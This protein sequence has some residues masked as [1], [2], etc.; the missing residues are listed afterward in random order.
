MKNAILFY[1]AHAKY[2]LR[3]GNYKR[4]S[5][6]PSVILCKFSCQTLHDKHML[7]TCVP[8]SFTLP[9]SDLQYYPLAHHSNFNWCRTCDNNGQQTLDEEFSHMPPK[10]PHSPCRFDN[11]YVLRRS[12]S[13]I[14]E[15]V[16]QLTCIKWL[17]IYW[18][19]NVEHIPHPLKLY[20]NPTIFT[21]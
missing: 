12:T 6:T 1:I 16:Y 13:N 19:L 20:E 21:V 3:A 17:K 2:V 11:H 4:K 18:F 14:T 9:G 8:C 15:V 5:Q 10:S 7:R